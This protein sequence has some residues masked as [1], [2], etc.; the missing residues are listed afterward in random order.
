MRTRSP[1]LAAALLSLLVPHISRSQ[2]PADLRAAVRARLTALGQSDA[3][4]WG[5]FTS[6]SFTVVSTDGR[7]MT[8]A[9]RIAQLKAGSPGPAWIPQ[10]ERYHAVGAA[11]VHRFDF[12][13][14]AFMEVWTRE[15]GTWRAAD[16]QVTAIIP[17]SATVRH[18]IDSANAGYLGV[19]KRGDASA[20]TAYYTDNAL[21]MAPNMAAWQGRAGI[22]QGFTGFLSQFS[23]VD[24]R[25]ATSDIIITA[26]YAIERGTYAWTLHPKSGT[27]PDIVDNGK[28]LTVWER[29]D[30]GSWKIA[31][32]IN[33]SDRPGAM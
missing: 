30:D 18:A 21:V 7:S 5:R 32:D 17:D 1:F 24:A 11:F 14:V 12:A 29:Q 22:S 2:V 25:L 31:R 16:V 23:L 9:D 13:E 8:K 33:N 4:T 20:L 15:H 27:G 26:Y 19:F 28:Y 10:H 3:A 6:D